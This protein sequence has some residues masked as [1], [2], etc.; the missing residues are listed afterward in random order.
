MLISWSPFPS[1][2]FSFSPP[3]TRTASFL[4]CKDVQFLVL[5]ES[6]ERI[7]WADGLVGKVH[8]GLWDLKWMSPKYPP[9]V[10]LVLFF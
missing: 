9:S 10:G 4:L 3:T 1:S 8:S 2:P 5:C 6:K 7:S